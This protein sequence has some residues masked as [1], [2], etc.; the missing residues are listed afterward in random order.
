[1]HKSSIGDARGRTLAEFQVEKVP[2]HLLPDEQ[3]LYDR[4][5]GEIRSFMAAKAREQPGY[6][7][8]DLCA[9]SGA[10]PETRRVQRA[11]LAKKAIENRA[12]EKLRVVE[13]IF[14][15]HSG[16]QAIVFAGSNEMAREVSRRFLIPCVLS[17]C[18]KKERADIMDGMKSGAYRAVVA[19]RIFDE[20]VNLPD[21][22]LGVVIGG[23]ASTRQ[24]KQRLGRL[25]RKNGDLDAR[26]YEVVVQGTNEEA[27]SRARR[28]SDAY[29]GTRHIRRARLAGPA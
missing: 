4:L 22:K 18:M 5:S 8:S 9:E 3:A 28:K 17:H 24:A 14:R 10:D 27:R 2:V 29:K 26:L 12:A 13:D 16:Q 6:S 23:D 1:M 25:L 20:G 11:Y 19:N 7:W 21:I 15:L